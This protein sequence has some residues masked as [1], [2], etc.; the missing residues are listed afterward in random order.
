MLVQ[1]HNFNLNKAYEKM[2][3]NEIKVF[4][5]KTD[6][7]TVLKK[8]VEVVMTLLD[9][10]SKIGKWRVSKTKGINLPISNFIKKGS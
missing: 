4:T 9:F 7:F 3:Q 6:A 5:V 10:G 1:Y 8:D 2:I